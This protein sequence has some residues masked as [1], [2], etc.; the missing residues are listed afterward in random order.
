VT[1]LYVVDKCTTTDEKY[2]GFCVPK[3]VKIGSF[4]TELC[5]KIMGAFFETKSSFQ[6]FVH[7]IYVSF[8]SSVEFDCV[9][10]GSLLSLVGP[11]FSVMQS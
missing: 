11:I 3:I 1:F 2:L 6:D 4:L 7:V 5:K 9:L 10:C 8:A